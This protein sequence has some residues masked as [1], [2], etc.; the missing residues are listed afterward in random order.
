MKGFEHNKNRDVK[1][2][3]IHKTEQEKAFGKENPA[4]Q[5]MKQKLINKKRNGF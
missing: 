5:N 3:D 2:N 1:Q 4:P